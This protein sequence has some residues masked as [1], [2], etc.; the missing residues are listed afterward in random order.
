MRTQLAL[1]PVV[2]FLALGQACAPPRT[3]PDLGTTPSLAPRD[4]AV[5]GEWKQPPKFTVDLTEPAFLTL[6]V[7][8]PN[9]A[10]QLLAVTSTDPNSPFSA[11]SHVLQAAPARPQALNQPAGPI[12]GGAYPDLGAA[13]A[14]TDFVKETTQQDTGVITFA[15]PTTSPPIVTCAVPGVGRLS[16]MPKVALDRYL[17]VLASDKPV[18]GNAV[19]AALARLDVTGTPREVSERVAAF[20]ARES[21]AAHWG[22]RAIRY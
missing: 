13:C 9:H 14:V 17:L 18:A 6:F 21:G 20:A 22:A 7:V 8:V 1:A 19:A 16:S 11:G 3:V 15:T 4:V 10:A 12:E 5:G 2:A